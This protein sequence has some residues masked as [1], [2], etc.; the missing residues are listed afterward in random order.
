M[1]TLIDDLLAESTKAEKQFRDNLSILAGRDDLSDK[2]VADTRAMFEAN[3]RKTVA[4]L[5]NQATARL[6]AERVKMTQARTEAKKREVDRLRSTLGDQVF[7]RIVERRLES[8]PADDIRRFHGEAVEGFEK[9]LVAGLGLAIME[10]RATRE[11]TP[12]N[13][14]ALQALA[15]PSGDLGELQRRELD[16]RQSESLVA[17]LDPVAWRR[18]KALALG[19]DARYIEPTSRGA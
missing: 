12:A 18:D 1:Q 19:V 13:Y 7:A 15:T 6:E 10:E 8:M 16:L 11:P 4:D 2:G 9:E 3:Y 14:M 5:Q 17:E